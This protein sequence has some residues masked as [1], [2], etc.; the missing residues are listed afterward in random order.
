MV[1]YQA[2]SK[3][4]NMLGL[5][6]PGISIF[7]ILFFGC[8][9]FL[10][11][12]S[13]SWA[14]RDAAKRGYDPKKAM[15]ISLIPF[16]GVLAYVL[17]RPPL[18]TV[19]KEEQDLDIALKRRQLDEYGTCSNCGQAIRE[20][21]VYCPKCQL[22]LKDICSKCGKPLS[23]SWNA[24]PYCGQAKPGSSTFASPTDEPLGKSVSKI[25]PENKYKSGAENTENAPSHASKTTD[26]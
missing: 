25:H 17:K 26:K 9:I 12:M 6:G 8:L 18:Y 22:Q 5:L 24:C 1:K 10:Y 11:I 15:L 2:E 14:K 20:D 7:L 3:E 21:Y 16:A 23:L 4:G 13:I 19:D